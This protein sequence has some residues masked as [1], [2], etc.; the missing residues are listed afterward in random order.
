MP[1]KLIK[2]EIVQDGKQRVLLKTFDDATQERTPVV[3]GEKKNRERQRPYWY[4][5]LGTGRRKFF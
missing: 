4:W 3:Q 5:S 1:K 2:V